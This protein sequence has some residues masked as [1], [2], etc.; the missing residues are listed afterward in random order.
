MGTCIDGALPKIDR[1][2]DG[3]FASKGHR[4]GIAGLQLE[5]GQ[6]GCAA[7]RFGHRQHRMVE[8][9][10]IGAARYFDRFP[11]VVLLTVGSDESDLSW[12]GHLQLSTS[13]VA[14]W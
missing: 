14:I 9:G 2:I 1:T 11:C 10:R 4:R 13:P 7:A 3:L 5:L 6:R 12:I 8:H